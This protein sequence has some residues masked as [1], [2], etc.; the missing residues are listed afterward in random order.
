MEV[1]ES[2]NVHED[3]KLG[4]PARDKYF[5]YRFKRDILSQVILKLTQKAFL[6]LKI[7]EWIL[8]SV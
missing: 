5:E 6:T 7:R 2:V 8:Y 1:I 3:I 4:L